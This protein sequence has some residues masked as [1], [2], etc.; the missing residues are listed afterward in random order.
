MILT[1]KNL[2]FSYSNKE[3]LHNISFSLQ[4]GE[5][6]TILGKNGVGKT[7]L[8]EL[9]LS[10]KKVKEGSIFLGN[11]DLKEYS[12]KEKSKLIAY[13]PQCLEESSLTVYDFLLLGR[14]PYFNLFPTKEDKDEVLHIINDFSLEAIVNNSMME[15]SGGERQ[16][17]SIAR[18]MLSKPKI[19]ILDEPTSSLDIQNTKKVLSTLKNLVKKQNI[20][21]LISIHD[22]NEALYLSDRLIM[23]KDGKVLHDIKPNMI[24][25][26]IIYETYGIESS[27]L[28][29]KEN[30]YIDFYRKD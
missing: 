25:E 9:L 17:V 4:E 27:I 30:L 29:N 1:V 18:A 28:K 7:T 24:T 12:A 11:K 5:I 26:D 15:I 21:I 19:L 8:L 14:I 6:V 20:T 23:F 13:V 2:S 22:I 3:V 16:L 10:L